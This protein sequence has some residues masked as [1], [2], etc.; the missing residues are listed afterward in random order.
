MAIGLPWGIDLSQ[1]P[2]KNRQHAEQMRPKANDLLYSDDVYVCVCCGHGSQWTFQHFWETYKSCRKPA[3]QFL[4][5][6]G[7]FSIPGFTIPGFPLR[8]AV[9]IYIYIHVYTYL[10]ASLISLHTPPCDMILPHMADARLGLSC[11]ATNLAWINKNQDPC[12]INEHIYIY[13]YVNI[14]YTHIPY[15]YKH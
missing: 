8:W 3:V 5:R 6:F 9:Y 15:I 1:T 14:L 11:K 2:R 12:P 4:C 10:H 7:A 13:I